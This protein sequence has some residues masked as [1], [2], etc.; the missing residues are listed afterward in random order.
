MNARTLLLLAI[1]AAVA[2]A[3][4]FWATS[5]REPVAA[6]GIAAPLV[7]GLEEKINEVA[8]IRVYSVAEDPAVTIS[9]SDTAW[10]VEQ[11][12]GY[13]ADHGQVRKL[14][15]ALADARLLEEK[16]SNP[17]Y[18]P[19]IGVQDVAEGGNIGIELDGMASPR[20]IVGNSESFRDAFYTRR[21]SE[22]TSWLASGD[23]V[24]QADPMQWLDREVIDLPA[25]QVAEVEVVH[26]DGETLRLV[27]DTFG[28]PD[29]DV[30]GLPDDA[31]LER[32]NVANPIGSALASLRFDDV[33]S[34]ANLALPERTAR[35]TWRTFDGLVVTADV[36]NVD[37]AFYAR[38][39]AGTDADI[40]AKFQSQSGNE[41]A[42]EPAV[43]DDDAGDTDAA[44]AAGSAAEAAGSAAE[45]AGSAAE[46]AGS[47]AEAAGSA[48]KAAGSAVKAATDADVAAAAAPDMSAAQS[49]ADELNDRL[50][51]WV[52][53]LPKYKYDQ[54]TRRLADL[55]KAES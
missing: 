44:E 55:L 26:A 52:Y 16:T 38:F 10:L 29:F 21:A 37:D 9:R 7:P 6:S 5:V 34:E 24:A 45:A 41:Q 49:R 36:S 11:K 2:L 40:A 23:I 22:A 47:A 51:G 20:L 19:R 30:A 42:G 12:D 17:A 53:K 28:Q 13:R 35:V 31:E 48:V 50:S 8:A 4:G 33:A 1:A 25:A 54:M 3:G 15:L 14:L 18:Y 27:K 39:E 32:A 43:D 46:A